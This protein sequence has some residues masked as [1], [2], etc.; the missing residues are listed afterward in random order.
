[1]ALPAGGAQRTEVF[2]MALLM[3]E[4]AL[5][6]SDRDLCASRNGQAGKLGICICFAF[7]HETVVM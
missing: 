3:E 2:E 6:N 1:V 5:E 4:K 7:L